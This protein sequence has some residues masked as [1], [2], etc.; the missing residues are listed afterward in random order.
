MYA[1]IAYFENNLGEKRELQLEI[2][3]LFSS[4]RWEI[5]KALSKKKLSPIELAAEMK[6]TSA[7]VSQ[8]L[9]LLELGGL[10]KSERISNA[11]KGKPRIIYSLSGDEAFLIISSPKFTD[12]KQFDLTAYH[13]YMMKSW[14]IGTA[15]EQTAL[16]ELYFLLKSHLSSIKLICASAQKGMGVF[17][18]LENQKASE[19]I[20]KI[21]MDFKKVRVAISEL[22]DIR[23]KAASEELVVLHGQ[24]E[25]IYDEV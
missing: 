16:G 23:K 4:T 21:I 2:E 10:I 9:R 25:I 17:I 15:D 13:K 5:L 7:N 6:T 24:D 1:E 11:D 8:Q 22:V 14:F 19:P 18:V 20:K 12:K 3:S